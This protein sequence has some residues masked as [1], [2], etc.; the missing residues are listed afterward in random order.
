M[1]SSSTDNL[2]FTSASASL[3]WSQGM[4]T[5]VHSLK[6]CNMTWSLSKYLCI[7]YSRTSKLPFTWLTTRRESH[8]A[9]TTSAPGLLASSRPAI[10]A[11]YSTLLLVNF[12]VFID[13]LIMRH[14]GSFRTMPSPDPFTFEA[15]SVNRVH[16]P[17]DVPVSSKN[18][19]FTSGMREGVKSATNSTKIWDLIAVRGWYTMSYPTSSMAHLA[20]LPN[21][22]RFCK[23]FQRGYVVKTHIRWH[24]K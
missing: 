8:F 5:R 17:D 2:R 22:S 4:W 9:S 12:G 10:I 20:N 6:R 24:W 23:M 15:L 7:L 21:N 13:C 3:F 18:S 19:L 14:V 11:S 1:S 16:T